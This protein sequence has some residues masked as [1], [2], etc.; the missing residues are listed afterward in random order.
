MATFNTVNIYEL[1]QIEEVIPGNYLIVQNENGTNIIDFQNFVVGPDNVSWY[2]NFTSSCAQ[3]TTT[4]NSLCDTTEYLASD[5]DTKI[6]FI[7]ANVVPVTTLIKIDTVGSNTGVIPSTIK[8]VKVTLVG[9]GGAGGGTTAVAGGIA[10]GGGASGSI[11]VKYFNN[12]SGLVFSYTVGTG[13]VGSAGAGA[14]GG[15]TTFTLGGITVTAKGGGGGSAGALQNTNVLGGVP[16]TASSNGDINIT[17]SHGQNSVSTGAAA[18]ATGGNGAPGY[19]G[20]GAGRG[21]I[22]GAGIAGQYGGAGGGGGSSTGAATVIGGNG[23]NGL[24]IIEY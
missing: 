10:G 7:S 5:L 11:C 20:M 18:T 9:A 19:L 24:I 21:G 8:T 23:A 13:G 4:V 16:S 6:D 17:G 14:T 22:A 12:V 2:T 1:N 15:D 3:L